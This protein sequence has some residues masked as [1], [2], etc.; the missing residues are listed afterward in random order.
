MKKKQT[1]YATT[2]DELMTIASLIHPLTAIPQVYSIYSTQDVS[3]VSLWTWL[4][5]MVIGSIFLLYAILHKLKPL[6][7]NQTLWFIVDFMVVIGVMLFN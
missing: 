1:K 2:V 4:G 3:G 5:F 6:I 7:V